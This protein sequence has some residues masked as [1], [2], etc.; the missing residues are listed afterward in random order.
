MV[1]VWQQA[2]QW[3]QQKHSTAVAAKAKL[4]RGGHD[5]LGYKRLVAGCRE[6]LLTY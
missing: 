3:W 6:I 2:V 5:E 4:L 1:D